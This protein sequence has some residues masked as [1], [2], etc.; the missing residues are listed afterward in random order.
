MYK[1]LGLKALV[2]LGV[3][4]LSLILAFPLQEKINLG[5]DLEGGMHLVYRADTSGLTAK[6]KN[7]DLVGVSY[8]GKKRR[9]TKSCRNY[10]EPYR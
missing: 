1:N 8:S 5:L 10:P 3:L 2:V 9:S 7:G 4:G 6:E